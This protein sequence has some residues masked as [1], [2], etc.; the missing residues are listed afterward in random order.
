MHTMA[1]GSL[2]IKSVRLFGKSYVKSKLPQK[3]LKH[4]LSLSRTMLVKR[5]GWVFGMHIS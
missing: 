2:A 4:F 1:A 5:N 3:I